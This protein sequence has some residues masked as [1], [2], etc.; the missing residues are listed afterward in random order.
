MRRQATLPLPPRC[1]WAVPLQLTSTAQTAY[2]NAHICSSESL[3][4]ARTQDFIHAIF[5]FL[6]S[7]YFGF[8]P[9]TLVPPPSPTAQCCTLLAAMQLSLGLVAP[10][11]AQAILEASLFRQH[12]AERAAADLPPEKG[13]QV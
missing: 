11:V 13:W 6:D 2:F 8:V 10:L 4:S 7:M 1:S 3:S 12:Q 9:S 5:G